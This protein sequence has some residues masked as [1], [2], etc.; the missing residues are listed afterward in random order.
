M[1]TLYK[2]MVRSLLEYCSPLWNSKNI[3]DIQ[4]LE[5]VQRTFTSRIGGCYEL[6]YWERL[7]KLSLMSLQRRRERYI[8]L[9]MWKNSPWCIQQ[10]PQCQVLHSTPNGNTS[11]GTFSPQ[12]KLGCP[13]DALWLIFCCHGAKTLERRSIQLEPDRELRNL[14][15]EAD[16]HY[17][18]DSRQTA[19]S[20]I[21]HCQLELYWHGGW[22]VLL[23]NCGVVK[24]V[25]SP[26][27]AQRSGSKV[28]KVRY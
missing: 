16:T 5:G 17:P 10:W 12:K 23:Q 24:I 21:Q 6:D 1:L 11:G 13:P 4:I 15:S 3:G 9:H 22:T 28:S 25:D 7:Q 2:S 27:G 26:A 20:R 19:C 8:I 18:N 14:Q